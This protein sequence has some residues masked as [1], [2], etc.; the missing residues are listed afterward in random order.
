MPIDED[1]VRKAWD[2]NADLWADRVR[3]GMDL[4]REAFNNPS[5]LAALP[6][7][8]GRDVIDLGCG[9]GT[10]TR[11]L[12]RRGARMT[13]IDLSPQMIAAAHAE[14]KR[15]PLGIAYDVAS[16]TTRTPFPDGRFD[17][18]VST[19]ALMDSPDFPAAARETFRL[20]K[21]GAPFIFSVLH[22]CFVTPGIRWLKDA[23]GRDTELVVS[24]Y[25]DEGSFVERWRFSK[26][27]EAELFEKF[28]VPRFPRRLETYVNGLI[29][30]GFRITR[31]TE[32]RPT[33]EMAAAHPWLARWREHAAIFL[34]IA[35]EK[36][37][38][39]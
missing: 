20:L 31:L 17:A 28:E 9:E 13:G 33:E 24:R 4:Y 32:P 11:L 30:A 34:Y 38:G 15:E 18:A 21:P 19:M 2:R 1:E 25:F 16:Y 26:D 8:T 27:P 35:A 6:D 22:P 37:G 5:F 39:A 10:N 23:E 7:L 3:A 36:P 29:D 12:A 14:E